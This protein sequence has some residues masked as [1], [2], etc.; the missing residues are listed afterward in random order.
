MIKL[1]LGVL[2][3]QQKLQVWFEIRS[4]ASNLFWTQ[5]AFTKTK[6]ST[7]KTEVNSNYMF[8]KQILLMSSCQKPLTER[9][10]ELALQVEI[11][12]KERIESL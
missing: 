6:T 8:A 12:K 5:W 11:F 7:P 1:I 4:A 10:C 3:E 2:E 9:D